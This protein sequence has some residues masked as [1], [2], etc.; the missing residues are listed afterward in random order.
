MDHFVDSDRE[1]IVLEYVPEYVPGVNLR[2]LVTER[3][4]QKELRVLSITKALCEILQYLHDQNPPVVHRDLT[5]DNIMLTGD[6]D[7]S[8]KLIDFGAARESFSNT[9]GT[10]IGKQSYIAPE[11]FRG[12]TS[13]QSDLYALGCTM[14]FLLTGSDPEALT[15][16]RPKQ[17]EASISVA[18]DDLVAS[19]TQIDLTNRVQTASEL[20]A[21]IDTVLAHIAAGAEEPGETV[22]LRVKE[23]A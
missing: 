14:H 11:Q 18:V 19:C 10:L 5:P 4:P 1:Y 2:Q 13:V 12:K 8:I 20:L 6:G 15:V 21:R 16:S 22:N 23:T 7:D 3:G 9:T 17:C